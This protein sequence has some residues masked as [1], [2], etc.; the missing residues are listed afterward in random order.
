MYTVLGGI[1]L[2]SVQPHMQHS[3]YTLIFNLCMKLFYIIK[4]LVFHL[5]VRLARHLESADTPFFIKHRQHQSSGIIN[6]SGQALIRQFAQG[7]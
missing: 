1:S 3:N 2:C 6:V 7:R 5:L 4:H